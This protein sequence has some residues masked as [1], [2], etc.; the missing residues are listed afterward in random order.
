VRVALAIAG[1]ESDRESTGTVR[2]DTDQLIRTLAAGQFNRARPVGFRADA[3]WLAAA[4][5]SLLM[6]FAELASADVMTAI[7]NPFYRP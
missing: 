5:V 4:P 2:M 7:R 1:C 6:F 3:G